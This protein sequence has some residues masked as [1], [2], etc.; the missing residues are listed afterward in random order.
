MARLSPTLALILTAL[1][2]V[3]SATL[4]H[5][6]TVGNVGAVNQST[7]GTPPGGGARVLTLGAGVVHNERVQTDANGSAQIAFSDGSAMSI[8]HNSNVTIDN[9][10]FDPATGAGAQAASMAKGALRFVGGKISH[11]EG[12]TISTPTATIGVRGGVATI[13]LGPGAGGQRLHVYGHYGRVT[14]VNAAGRFV[15]IRNDFDIFV[16]G[17]GSPPRAGG[18]SDPDALAAIGATMSSRRREHGGARRYPSDGELARSGVA[19]PRLRVDA[20][21]VD[22]FARGDAT[23]RGPN[24]PFFWTLR[25][26]GQVSTPAP[27]T[28]P[29]VPQVPAVNPTPAVVPP[30]VVITT[31]SPVS[32]IPPVVTGKP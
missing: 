20:P 6:Q 17:P 21:D 9:Y 2:L 28:T 24:A 8:A 12:V 29:D 27:A 4:V 7:K 18:V 11:E 25:Y 19:S 32:T 30:P 22:V 16:D 23:V 31:P 10:A 1:P 5:A 15:S 3:R 26:P 14:V 13:E